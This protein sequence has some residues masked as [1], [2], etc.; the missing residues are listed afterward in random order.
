M[1]NM[2]QCF[3]KCHALMIRV[4]LVWEDV[5][6][7]CLNVKVFR[8]RRVVIVG[9]D[10]TDWSLL[11]VFFPSGI[12]NL[13]AALEVQRRL[14]PLVIFVC[15]SDTS[16]VW[17]HHLYDCV[18]LCVS[19]VCFWRGQRDCKETWETRVTAE[20]ETAREPTVSTNTDF[21]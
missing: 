6:L 5:L 3:S 11:S 14:S 20:R 16:S 13:P 12:E 7:V 19:A 8:W 9:A 17:D 21:H 4:R 18:C 15:Y 10:Q 2:H 1:F